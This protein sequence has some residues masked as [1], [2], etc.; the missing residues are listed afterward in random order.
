MKVSSNLKKIISLSTKL[1]VWLADCV[2]FK[3]RGREQQVYRLKFKFI[4]D[5]LN[6]QLE[7]TLYRKYYWVHS[8]T[9]NL[10]NV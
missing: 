10:L 1:T 6:S 3:R 8:D 4:R 7:P 2:S 5:L 9:P